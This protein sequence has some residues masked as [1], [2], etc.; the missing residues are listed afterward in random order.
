MKIGFTYNLRDKESPDHHSPE[1]FYGEFESRE[2]IA[3]IT[4]TLTELG[5]KVVQIGN[6]LGLVQ[7]LTEKKQ[8]EMIFNMSEGRYGRARE[9]QIPGVLEAYRIPYTFSDPYTLAVCLDKGLTKDILTKAGIPNAVYQ[10]FQPGQHLGLQNLSPTET[11]YFLKPLYEGTSKGID[12]GAIVYTHAEIENRVQWLWQTYRQPVLLEKYLL[13]REF[14]V[15]VLGTGP[16]A[17]VIGALEISLK[18]EREVYGFLEKEACEELVRYRPF[19]EQ[20]LL[21][22]LSTLALDTWRLLECRDGGR[23]DIRL[24]EQDRPFVLEVNTLPGMHPTHSDLPMIAKHAGM[25]YAALLD[26]I[27]SSAQLR[28]DA[29]QRSPFN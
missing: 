14:T 29:A 24:D 25:S 20:P 28:M 6:M 21:A 9:S 5:H 3:A 23:V 1:D 26:E 7:F 16:R 22:E 19:D 10:V 12:A 15:G 2:T 4:E 8:V 18:N 17:R 11:G 13:G 27:L